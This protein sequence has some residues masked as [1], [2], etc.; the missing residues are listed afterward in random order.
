MRRSSAATV[1]GSAGH[2]GSRLDILGHPCLGNHRGIVAD[3][4]VVAQANLPR[5]RH[6]R[7]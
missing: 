2:D 3:V 6:P 5:E 7:P 4:H 1:R